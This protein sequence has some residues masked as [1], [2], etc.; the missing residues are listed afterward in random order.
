LR[1]LEP[2]YDVETLILGIP[3]ILKDVPEAK[4]IIAG[5]GP[6]EGKLRHLAKSLGVMESISFVGYI[7]SEEIPQYLESS[8]IYVSTSLSDAG[9]AASTAEAM[10][11]GLPVII[12]NSGENRLWVQDGESGFL[13]PV[14]NPQ[15]LAE[16][17]VTLLKREDLRIK[18]G[19]GGRKVIKEKNNYYVEMAKMETIYKE[20]AK[21]CASY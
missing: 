20:L 13:I 6:E 14:K 15:I 19:E 4:F 9:I 16:R 5:R 7:P 12:T 8:D 11:S 1:T 2:I 3:Y 21:S 17:I 10:A 18:F